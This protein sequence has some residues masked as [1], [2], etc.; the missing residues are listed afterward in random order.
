MGC[1][2]CAFKT[3]GYSARCAYHCRYPHSQPQGNGMH[4]ELKHH[5]CKALSPA[6]LPPS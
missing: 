3:G 6:F 1:A 2:H 5:Y 4:A